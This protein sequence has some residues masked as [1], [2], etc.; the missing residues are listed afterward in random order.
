MLKESIVINIENR[1]GRTVN[2]KFEELDVSPAAFG[3]FLTN[4]IKEFFPIAAHGD[5]YK[6]EIITQ[7]YSCT[8]MYTVGM[9]Y[10]ATTSECEIE[11]F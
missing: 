11:A 6:V 4:K 9:L 5:I 3:L 2:V 1:E 10:S 8:S 7:D